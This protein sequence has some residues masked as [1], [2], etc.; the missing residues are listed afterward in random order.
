MTITPNTPSTFHAPGTKPRRTRNRLLIG[1]AAVV[2]VGG[3]VSVVM[4]NRTQQRTDSFAGVS[5]VIVEVE[6]GNLAI[7]RSG[8]VEVGIR[9]TLNVFLGGLPVADRR[10]EN[11][12]LTI[13]STCP[14]LGV[15][16]YVED[17]LTIPA[18]IRV[19]V[20]TTTGNVEAT[21]IDVPEFDVETVTGQVSGSFVR[22]PDRIA[23]AVVTGTVD[24][25]VP[26]A[27]Y[28]FDARTTTGTIHSDV[29]NNPTAPRSVQLSTVTGTISVTS[30]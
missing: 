18:G 26:A 11:G 2:L 27:D 20:R 21:D 12:V 25:T 6:N 24:L 17:E 7:S 28:R 29:W 5:S 3:A 9:T 30:R 23:I 13:T 22:P 10:L 19:Q 15:N 4:A 1:A 8:D 14:A 16:C